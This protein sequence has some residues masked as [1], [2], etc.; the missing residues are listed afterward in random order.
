MTVEPASAQG[1]QAP[2]RLRH[3]LPRC[4]AGRLEFGD[5]D[6]D[7]PLLTS[8]PADFTAALTRRGLAERPRAIGRARRWI[9]AT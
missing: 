4:W 3:L 1:R 5:P 2:A 7:Y 6:D 9:P 8:P